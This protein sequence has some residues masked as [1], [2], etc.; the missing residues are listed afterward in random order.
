MQWKDRQ[1]KPGTKRVVR[2]FAWWPI[3]LQTPTNWGDWIWLE[4]YYVNQVYWWAS[5]SGEWKYAQDYDY[6][7]SKNKDDFN[8][9][10]KAE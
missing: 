9:W 6:A 1:P 4:F 2:K 7:V 3:R 5:L 10:L 8:S